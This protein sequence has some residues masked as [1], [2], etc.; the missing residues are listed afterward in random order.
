LWLTPPPF[1]HLS[2]VN[3]W[4]ST[5][6][7][8]RSGIRAALD[9]TGPTPRLRPASLVTA[10]VPVRPP[11]PTLHLT[12]NSSRDSGDTRNTL[13][14]PLTCHLRRRACG[15]HPLYTA[16]TVHI[17]D[18]A[19]DSPHTPDRIRQSAPPSVVT[20]LGAPPRLPHPQSRRCLVPENVP[21]LPQ[22]SLSPLQ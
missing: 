10:L 1:E 19:A 5:H 14:P 17:G 11:P 21:L 16:A 8:P 20:S 9:D 13:A 2:A 6:S 12:D 15:W 7:P 18:T 3:Y 22:T 4:R